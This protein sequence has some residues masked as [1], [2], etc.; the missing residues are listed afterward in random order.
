MKPPEVAPTRELRGNERADAVYG[1]FAPLEATRVLGTLSAEKLTE[2]GLGDTQR[3]LDV[4]VAGTARRFK[5]S[6]PLP[7]IIG[8]WLLD[9]KTGQ[10]SLMQGSLFSELDPASQVLV[11]RRLHT[12]RPPEVD[13]LTVTAGGKTAEFLF[14]GAE[15]PQNTKVARV[16]SPEKSEELVKNWHEKLWG[17]VIVTE[18]LGRG[19]LPKLGEPRVELRVEYT[20]RG[21]KKGFLE[22]GFDTSAATWARTENTASWVAVHQGA[23]EL[24]IEARKI[25]EGP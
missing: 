17:R 5:V 24:V 11:D 13:R 1:R 16:A 8:T 4:T 25:A 6:K 23:D 3:L 7:G 12:F 21:A 10:V 22:I 2:L 19:E 20:A 14:T 18:V 9:A 15:V